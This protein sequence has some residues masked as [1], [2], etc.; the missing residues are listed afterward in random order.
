MSA[1]NDTG[2]RKIFSAV[3]MFAAGFVVVAGVVHLAVGD[4]LR[5]Y[6]DMRSEKLMV[7]DEWQG[8]AYSAAFG[9]SHVH[10]GFDPRIVRSGDGWN[11]A[12][13]AQPEPGDPGWQPKRAAS[14][15]NSVSAN[16]CKSLPRWGEILR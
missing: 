7:M 14:H 9:S 2:W 13:D 15:G 8:R 10:Y 5:L 6:A 4:P 3:A 12:A 11:A 1:I 16:I